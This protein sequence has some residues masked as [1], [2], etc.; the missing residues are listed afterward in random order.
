MQKSVFDNIDGVGEKVKVDL[1]NFFGSIENI[2]TA[3]LEELKKAPGIGEKI[4][5]NIY[6]EFNKIV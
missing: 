3:S 5:I 4:A 6:E 1:I 2:K